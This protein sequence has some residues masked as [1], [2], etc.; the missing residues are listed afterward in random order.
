MYYLSFFVLKY[1]RGRMIIMDWIVLSTPNQ[2][3]V[4]KP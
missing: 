3:D 2:T 4:F 1:K